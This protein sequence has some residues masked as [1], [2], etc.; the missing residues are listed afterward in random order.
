MT[1]DGIDWTDLVDGKLWS[2]FF[3]CTVHGGY[4]LIQGVSSQAV[5]LQL[6]AFIELYT[7]TDSC[8][9]N[10]DLC[11]VNGFNLR[12]RVRFSY[13]QEG[14][15][16]IS[17]GAESPG[18]TGVTVFYQYGHFH[19]VFASSTQLWYTSFT[20]VTLDQW[21]LFD[22]SWSETLGLLVYVDDV[23]VAWQQHSVTR[24]TA[25]AVDLDILYMGKSVTWETSVN[26]T[27]EVE[28]F[29]TY[30]AT[31]EILIG[32]G[33]LIPGKFLWLSILI[34][35]SWCHTFTCDRNT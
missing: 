8:I 27:L 23:L 28:E 33:I 9:L 32:K 26:I 34:S 22:F 19:V 30:T 17:S 10:L 24:I 18:G 25:G 15:Y 21:T 7:Q 29:V 11:A 20:G 1:I 16:V 13:L 14:M 6:G 4:Q 5:Q 2:L 31:R 12:T 3:N 35:L